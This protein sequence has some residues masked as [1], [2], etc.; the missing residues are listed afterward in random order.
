M[1]SN[2]RSKRYSKKKSFIWSRAPKNGVLTKHFC[3]ALYKNREHKS[4]VVKPLGPVG[5]GTHPRVNYY[6]ADTQ[7]M[8]PYYNEGNI[9]Y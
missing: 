9:Q 2:L 3:G 6:R 8:L 1:G 5:K 4:N 7:N